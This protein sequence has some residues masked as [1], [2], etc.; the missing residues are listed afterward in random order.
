MGDSTSKATAFSLDCYGEHLRHFAE[1]TSVKEMLHGL[2]RTR[3]GRWSGLALLSAAATFSLSLFVPLLGTVPAVGGVLVWT[4][5]FALGFVQFGGIILFAVNVFMLVRFRQGR[6]PMPFPNAIVMAQVRLR[7]LMVAIEQQQGYDWPKLGLPESVEKLKKIVE[8]FLQASRMDS[9]DLQTY[10]QDGVA[11]TAMQYVSRKVGIGDDELCHV[12]GLANRVVDTVLDLQNSETLKIPIVDHAHELVWAVSHIVNGLLGRYDADDECA[13]EEN[14]LA[15][16]S[17]LYTGVANAYLCWWDPNTE[18]E[19]QSKED[20]RRRV[21]L[22]HNQQ[23]WASRRHVAL[24]AICPT[25]RLSPFVIPCQGHRRE[26]E[27]RQKLAEWKSKIAA[28]VAVI[29]E[30]RT[31]N[32]D[33]KAVSLAPY[34]SGKKT[35]GI[36]LFTVPFAELSKIHG[37]MASLKQE[38]TKELPNGESFLVKH[39]LYSIDQHPPKEDSGWA[40]IRVPDGDSDLSSGA[41]RDLDIPVFFQRVQSLIRLKKDKTSADAY[42]FVDTTLLAVR[43]SSGFLQIT[44]GKVNDDGTA[45]LAY[46]WSRF[47][48]GDVVDADVQIE[49][50]VRDFFFPGDNLSV[51]AE[52]QRLALEKRKNR[53]DVMQNLAENAV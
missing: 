23:K 19:E 11:G 36:A 7:Q 10:K 48:V 50:K 30:G 38:E 28:D 51:R 31:I 46:P 42:C 47:T 35:D 9:T 25:F 40:V 27:F 49:Q 5:S 21:E 15:G 12:L 6:E 14:P 18:R 2:V 24:K 52:S 43:D 41:S 4:F 33:G 37:G 16:L 8:S 44:S 3:I 32:I 45:E 20:L 22:L 29:A 53:R 39:T 26:A 34:F 17:P 1:A 13:S